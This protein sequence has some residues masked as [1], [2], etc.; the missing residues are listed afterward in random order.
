MIMLARVS[1]CICWRGVVLVLNGAIG[2][3]SASH[4]CVSQS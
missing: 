2:F 3:V 1:F 4:Q